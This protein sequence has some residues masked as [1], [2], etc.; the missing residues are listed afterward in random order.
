MAAVIALLLVGALVLYVRS[1]SGRRTRTSLADVAKRVGPQLIEL[2][3]EGTA[4]GERVRALAIEESETPN[5]LSMLA[6]T[7]ATSNGPIRTGDVVDLLR[8]HDL[9]FASGG[10]YSIQTRAWLVQEP[11]FTEVERGHWALGDAAREA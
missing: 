3:A 9:R 11:C 7:F 10:R 1:D 8:A 4:A 6:H 5:A 2:L